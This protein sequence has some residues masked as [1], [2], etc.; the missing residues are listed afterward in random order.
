MQTLGRQSRQWQLNSIHHAYK[1]TV[2]VCVYIYI[3]SPPPP[4]IYV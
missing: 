1:N 3:C 4:K 2:Y